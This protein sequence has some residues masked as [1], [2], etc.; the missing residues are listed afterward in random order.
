MTENEVKR[1]ETL[2]ET[3]KDF[4]MTSGT[5]ASTAETPPDPNA[6]LE[7]R[8]LKKYFPVATNFFGRPTKFLKSG[9][10]CKFQN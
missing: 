7:I 10:R 8:H 2:E 3:K 1:E 4:S 5:V 9:G 6:L